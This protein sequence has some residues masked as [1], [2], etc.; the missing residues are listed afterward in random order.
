MKKTTTLLNT[1]S[2]HYFSEVLPRL[3]YRGIFKVAV[4]LV[5]AGVV[6]ASGK[7][8]VLP[9]PD[10]SILLGGTVVRNIAFIYT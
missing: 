10:G 5:F 4:T 6:G 7:D 2:T 3:F 8:E 9:Q 1:Y